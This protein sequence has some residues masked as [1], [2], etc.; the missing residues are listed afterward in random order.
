MVPLFKALLVP[1]TTPDVEYIKGGGTCTVASSSIPDD[2]S[3]HTLFFEVSA[4]RGRAASQTAKHVV[5]LEAVEIQKSVKGEETCVWISSMPRF[6]LKREASV[7]LLPL[8][9]ASIVQEL[10]Y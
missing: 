7:S 8:D 4:L 6:L 10:C 2:E 3:I 5:T 9:W 1:K